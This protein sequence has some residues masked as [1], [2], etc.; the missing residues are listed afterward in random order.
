MCGIAGLAGPVPRNG[1]AVI[2]AMCEAIRHRGPDGA[3][4]VALHPGRKHCYGATATPPT[5]AAHVWL[6]HRRLRVIDLQGS[7]QPLRNEDGSVWVTFNGEI[8]NHRAL[9]DLLIRK[10]HTLREAGDTEVLVHLWEEYGQGMLEHLHGMFAFAIYDVTKNMLFLARDRFGKKPLYYF[11]RGGCFYFASELQA[12]WQTGE[13]SQTAIDPIAAAQYFRY[14]YIPAPRTI[15]DGVSSLSPG[16]YA[17]V[18]DGNLSVH[19]Y[20]RPHVAGKPGPVDYDL[21]ESQLDA[22]VAT[23]L[24]SD[25]PI[26][27]LL[28]GGVDSG[29]TVASM[30]R[31]MDMRPL[32]FT[33]SSG[34]TGQDESDTAQHI[35]GYLGTQHH[36]FATLP[37]IPSIASLLARHYGQPFADSSAIPTYSVCKQAR[38]HVTVALTGDGGD[39]LFWGYQRYRNYRYA[40]ILRWLP[41]KQRLW[42][43]GW[44]S[45]RDDYKLVPWSK[46]SAFIFSL[47]R[48]PERGE[49]RAMDY[50]FRRRASGLQPDFLRTLQEEEEAG[51]S[52]FTDYYNQCE[53]DNP[54]ARWLE[55]DQ[56]MYLAGDILT[57]VDIASMAVSLECR[58]PLLD[59]D[60]ANTANGIAMAA[61][62]RGLRTKPVL[63]KLAARRLPA[64]ITR[65]PKKGF[66]VPVSDWLRHRLSDWSRDLLFDNVAT[67]EPWL[68]PEFVHD[69]WDRHQSGHA[70]HSTQLWT[71]MAWVLWAQSSSIR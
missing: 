20:W 34:E 58:C 8:Y 52:Q 69:L 35:A 60:F 40:S 41:R 32:T 39:E 27:A 38:Q 18:Q 70:N 36:T 24:Q 44:M 55:A 50:D 6:G 28:S 37:D 5:D 31:Q 10:G 53:S 66:T 67:W 21:L 63:R 64:S 2:A 59:Y 65:L 4:F 23:R 71:V 42:L 22:A 3:G 12:L 33:L 61:K 43:A 62:M 47:Q 29:M 1:S 54:F 16:H 57:K 19:S 45:G 56:R 14:G 25:V 26:G 48:L 46:L 17:V 15:Y 30:A 11:Q 68:R 49:N 51:I 13:F 7:D 9:R